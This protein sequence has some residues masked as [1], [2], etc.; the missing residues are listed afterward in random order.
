MTSTGPPMLSD[1]ILNRTFLRRQL[2]DR[3]VRRPVLEVVEHL[4]ALQ[5]QEPNWPY[6]GLAA[7]IADVRPEDLEELL[8]DYRVVRAA[9]LRATQQLVSATDFLWLRAT[10]QPVLERTLRTPYFTEHT[11]GLDLSGLVETA[12]RAL[13]GRALTRSE[14]G[15]VLGKGHPDR[16]GRRLA[17]AVE[18][19][20]P[21]LHTPSVAA[22]GSWGNR[23][24]ISLTAAATALGTAV[25]AAPQPRLLVRR[26]LQAFGP[27]SVRDLQAWS[28]LTHQREIVQAMPELREFRDERGT[29]LFDLPDAPIVSDEDLP[30]PVRL[31]SAYDNA[32]LGHADRTRIVGSAE[33]RH[34]NPGYS[35]VRPTVLVDGFVAGT[36]SWNASMLTVKPTRQLSQAETTDVR[37]EAERTVAFITGSAIE[38]SVTIA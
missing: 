9:T 36:W 16:L 34:V 13:A 27:A 5:D 21:L 35:V 12:R 18:L 7:R 32:L 26:Y 15:E 24:A 6:V 11:A 28:G 29:R 14:L 1:R 33:R 31:L 30:A 38:D 23:S 22:W 4:V 25:A 37:E 2:L 17:A 19:A 8:S 3:R 20:M 10:V